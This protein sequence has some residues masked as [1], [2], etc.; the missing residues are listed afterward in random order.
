MKGE[1]LLHQQIVN[2][3]KVQYPDV[4]FRTD[5]AAGV[6]MTI[7]QAKRHKALQSDKCYP[8]LFIAQPRGRYAGAFIELKKAGTTIYKKNGEL[9]KNEHIRCQAKMLDRLRRRGYFATFACGFDEAKHIIDNYL[10]S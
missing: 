2:Y 5:F 10:R 1:A 6:K 8:D 7:G 4:I 3:L 9:V